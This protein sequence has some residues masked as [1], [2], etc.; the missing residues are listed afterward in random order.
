MLSTFAS[1]DSRYQILELCINGDLET[2]LASR[3]PPALEEDAL[4]GVVRGLLDALMY[5]RRER[6]IH[7]NIKPSS[8]LLSETFRVVC[9]LLLGQNETSYIFAETWQL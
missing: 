9:D 1:G 6:V 4:R 8:V 2:L 3:Q 5:L 7:R